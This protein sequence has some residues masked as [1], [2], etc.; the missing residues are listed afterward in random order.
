M[1]E[2]LK[3]TYREDGDGDPDE[4]GEETNSE[5]DLRK[6]RKKKSHPSQRSGYT[7]LARE[8]DVIHSSH[9]SS[10]QG[11]WEV[12]FCGSDQYMARSCL[13]VA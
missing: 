8:L 9:E 7:C 6:K 3:A 2:I 11:M 10:H 12:L 1:H 5:P 13:S 4:S